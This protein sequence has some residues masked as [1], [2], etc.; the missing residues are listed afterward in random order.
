[1]KGKRVVQ[2]VFFS[3]FFFFFSVCVCV[4]VRARVCVYIRARIGRGGGGTFKFFLSNYNTPIFHLTAS[5]N[6]QHSTG[7]KLLYYQ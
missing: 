6:Q 5:S 7:T 1:M 4:C 2:Y 3:F